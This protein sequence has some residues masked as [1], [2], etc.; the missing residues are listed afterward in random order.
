MFQSTNI[1]GLHAWSEITQA[2]VPPSVLYY[3]LSFQHM[4]VPVDG[5]ADIY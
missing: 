3:L 1:E 2:R 4:E 5:L